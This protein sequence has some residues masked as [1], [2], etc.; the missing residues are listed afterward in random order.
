MLRFALAQTPAETHQAYQVAKKAFVMDA[1][2]G[3]LRAV[4][5]LPVAVTA[6]RDGRR[7]T[8]PIVDMSRLILT[9]TS[10]VGLTAIMV[11]G[12]RLR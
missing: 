10:L 8:H 11:C 6:E 12:R 7:T 5:V 4:W 2:F 9:V 1:R 3:G